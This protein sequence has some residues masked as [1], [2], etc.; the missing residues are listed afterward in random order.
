MV[1]QKSFGE[2]API[3]LIEIAIGV[4]EHVEAHDTEHK[5]DDGQQDHYVKKWGAKSGQ[6][7]CDN[8]L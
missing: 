4:S 8:D 5:H 3:I 6:E 7:G 1:P 2:G